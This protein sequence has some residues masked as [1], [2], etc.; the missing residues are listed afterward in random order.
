MK[1]NLLRLPLLA[2][3][4]AVACA[5]PPPA[6]T[7][8]AQAP[9]ELPDP[10]T[11]EFQPPMVLD[12]PRFHLEPLGPQHAELDYEAFM[13]S[14]EHLLATLHW[15][16]WPSADATVEGNRADLTRHADEFVAGEA[17]AYTVLTPD[18]SAA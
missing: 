15:G 4:L 1:R 6:E 9:V 14:R 16:G 5:T 13:S 2:G 7:H 12:T 11:A 3:L 17:Y 18:R 8:E 10:W